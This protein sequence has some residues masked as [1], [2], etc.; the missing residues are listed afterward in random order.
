MENP[1]TVHFLG[2]RGSV[3]VNSEDVAVYGGATACILVSLPEYD[4]VID[5]GSGL[6][7]AEKYL[8]DKTKPLYIL[9]SH[10]HIDHVLGLPASALLFDQNRAITLFAEPR[11]GLSA[12]EQIS[13][14]MSFPLWPVG[15]EAFAKSFKFSTID[16]RENLIFGEKTAC[17]TR[18]SMMDSNHPGGNTIFRLD[19][20]EKSLVY[21][22]D[23]EHHEE[24]AVELISFSKDC[25]LL[26]IDAQYTDE[27]YKDRKGWGH[28]TFNQSTNTAKACNAVKTRLFHHDPFRTDI[29]LNKIQE[30]LPP[31]IS[32]AKAEEV[33]SL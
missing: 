14:L 20:G 11:G 2:T 29:Q 3:P 22:T 31:S 25:D 9:L 12:A 32:F 10:P 24:A 23:F 15:I 6:I 18:V 16:R 17:P 33:I 27:E 7:L 26:I 21:A 1:I 13:Y 19:I 28:S 4:I 5:C 30:D 8:T